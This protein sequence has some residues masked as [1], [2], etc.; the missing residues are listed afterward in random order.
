VLC[1]ALLAVASTSCAS[2]NGDRP[3]AVASSSGPAVPAVARTRLPGFD[4]TRITVRAAAGDLLAWCLLLA[5][6]EAQRQRGLMAVTD[7][8]LG[9]Y[10]GMLFRFPADTTVAFYMRNTPMPLSIAFVDR[11]GQLVSTA[12]MAPCEDRAGCPTYPA[13]GPF[14]VA[15]EVPEGQL[16]RLGITLGAT[17]T[18][19]RTGCG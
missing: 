5:Q 2:G 12:D 14:R 9:G 13:A 18:D 11:N 3:G 16:G 8:D 7:P 19:D 1:V 10:D 17:L 15:I 4:E 6:T